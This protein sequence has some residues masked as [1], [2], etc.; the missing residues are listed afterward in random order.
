MRKY[1]LTSALLIVFFSGYCQEKK[2]LEN[3]TFR[4]DRF[5]ALDF[6]IGAGG[7]QQNDYDFRNSTAGAVNAGFYVRFFSIKSTNRLLQTI[8]PGLGLSGGS[9]KGNNNFEN[10]KL[11]SLNIL[12]SFFMN[13]KWYSKNGFVEVGTSFSDAF[14]T[15]RTN[16][17]GASVQNRFY[18]SNYLNGN[19]TLGVGKGRLENITDMQNALWLHNILFKD[20]NLNRKLREEEIIGLARVITASNNRRILDGRR[21][22]QFVLKNIDGYLQSKDV[23]T[24]TDINYFSNLNDAVFFANNAARQSGTETYIRVIPSLVNFSVKDENR[25]LPS[26]KNTQSEAAA[27][28]VLKIG[29]QKY[30]PLSLT[31]QID[32]GIAA[33]ANYG[34]YY[35]RNNYYT[36]A[37]LDYG[38][39]YNNEWKKLGLDYFFSY[40]MY[41]NTRTIIDIKLQGENGYQS[42]NGLNKLYHTAVLAAN[43]NYFISY[44]TLLNVNLGTNYNQNNLDLRSSN[45]YNPSN[46]NSHNLAMFFSVGLNIAL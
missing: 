15:S 7:Q 6:N 9:T 31:R 33:K 5:K 17:S 11:K 29:L 40:S 13:N 22:I 8:S 19:V 16:Q 20:N 42:V 39:N 46:L 43:A 2:L 23:I 25:V 26:T 32:F 36:N 44:N 38:F 3:Y 41:P 1:L 21:R 35:S 14:S 30:K 45:P 4:I 28:V 24:K 34:E 10:S 18:N 37:S 12:P 27:E